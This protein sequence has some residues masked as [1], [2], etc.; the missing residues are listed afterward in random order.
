MKNCLNVLQ[1]IHSLG[2]SKIVHPW[3]WQRPTDNF[4]PRIQ[5][6]VIHPP[7]HL[8]HQLHTAWV[9]SHLLSHALVHCPW[10]VLKKLDKMQARETENNLLWGHCSQGSLWIP[11]GNKNLLSQY[12]EK[13]LLVLIHLFVFIF[14]MWWSM[15]WIVFPL[16]HCL[17]KSLELTFMPNYNIV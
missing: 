3:I 4:S 8:H 14:W 15:Q 2:S 11:L 1:S 12:Q 17:L 16:F 7:S 10:S 13:I 9:I 5:D 6:V